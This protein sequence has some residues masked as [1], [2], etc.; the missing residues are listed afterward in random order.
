M[1]TSVVVLSSDGKNDR[2]VGIDWI[3]IV[4]PELGAESK[5]VP[6]WTPESELVPE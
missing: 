4:G 5:L 6:E 1:N 3:G 2:F